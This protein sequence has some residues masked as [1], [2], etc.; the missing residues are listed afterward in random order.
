MSGLTPEQKTFMERHSNTYGW[1]VRAD[2]RGPE[3]RQHGLYDGPQPERVV[4]RREVVQ[5]APDTRRRSPRALDRPGQLALPRQRL[6]PGFRDLLRPRRDVEGLAPDASAGAV[7]Q[8]L[9]RHGQPLQGVRVDGRT[10]GVSAASWISAAAAIGS[11]R[12][13][14]EGAPGGEGSTH[15]IDPFDPNIVYSSGSTAR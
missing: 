1:G 9:V 12:W 13:T 8:H 14:F 15:A 2:P 7:L 4:R 10:T 3:R 11:C 5:A 6:R